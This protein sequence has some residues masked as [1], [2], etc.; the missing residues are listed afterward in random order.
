[1]GIYCLNIDFALK[2]TDFYDSSKILSKIFPKTHNLDQSGPKN[3]F[4]FCS[5]PSINLRLKSIHKIARFQFQKYRTFQLLKGA[6]SP[7][8]PVY[9]KVQLV[10]THHQIIFPP[11]PCRRR[12][13]ALDLYPPFQIRSNHDDIIVGITF[14]L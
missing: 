1:M 2:P 9:T 4:L 6:L 7:T 10:L 13:Y 14:Q 5:S 3:L 12:I 11:P 8:R